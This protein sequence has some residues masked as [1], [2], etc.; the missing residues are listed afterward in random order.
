MK[1]LSFR[2]KIIYAANTLVAFL[3]LI[4][5]VLPYLSPQRFAFLSVLSLSVP[6]LISI[7]ILFCLYWLIR[8]KRQ[9][10]LSV[11]VLLIGYNY[12]NSMY[13][14]ASAPPSTPNN[15][16]SVMSYNVR[17]F[18]LY[19]WIPKQSV[20][21]DIINFITTEK[22]DI[23]CLQEY[24]HVEDLLK[25]Y[26]KF[27][28]LSKGKVK[29]GQAIFSKFPIVN[30][31]SVQFPNT[32]NN[33]IFADVVTSKDTIR[34]YNLHLQSSGINTDIEALKNEGSNSL[35]KQVSS[36]FKLQQTQAELLLKHKSKCEYKT[37]IAGDFNNTAYSYIYK[38]IKH[39]Y[40]DTFE[41]AGSGFGRTFDFKYFP[42]RIDFILVDDKFS[43]SQ[44]KAFNTVKLSDHYPVKA[45]LNSD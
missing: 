11:F 23:L 12:I 1:K 22:P 4:A 14:L 43:V 2:N 44:H 28:V 35:F 20:K 25:N 30:S 32:A 31:G 21:A 19:N 5:Y 37:I 38:K 39:G 41:D 40:K 18:N 27:E 15:A 9:F 7:N 3:L 33:A 17:L 36:T 45:L 13:K 8:L 16:I 42:V 29:S 26:Y 6:L 34:V 10:I 24:H